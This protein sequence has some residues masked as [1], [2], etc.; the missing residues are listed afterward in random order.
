MSANTR[1]LDAGVS[2]LIVL[3]VILWFIGASGPRGDTRSAV[4]YGT[5]VRDDRVQAFEANHRRVSFSLLSS[6]EYFEVPALAGVVTT[7]RETIPE[8][9]RKLNG[10]RVSVDGFMMPLDFDGG[11][12]S[13]FIL[14]ASYDMCQFGAPSLVTQ[15]IDVSMVDGKRTMYTH[16]PIRVYG[17][18][19]VGEEYQRGQLVNIYRLKA[20]GVFFGSGY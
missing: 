7:G 10:T 17:T 9:I 14:N 13:L 5:V 1:W 4:D 12:V 2:L 3:G 20:D 11:G 6:F 19:E 8:E 15:R 18:M 16:L